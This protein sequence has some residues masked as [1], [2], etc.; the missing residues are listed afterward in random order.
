VQGCW[1]C[2]R[3]L[4]LLSW[5]VRE[6]SQDVRGCCCGQ[7]IHCY[8]LVWP[9]HASLHTGLPARALLH[10]GVASPC[11]V[12]HWFASYTLLWP[13]HVL[14]H[15]SVASPCIPAPLFRSDHSHGVC[16]C[17]FCCDHRLL[18]VRC[19]NQKLAVHI[20]V[21]CAPQALLLR[22]VRGSGEVHLDP[23]VGAR[24]LCVR[25]ARRNISSGCSGCCGCCGS[26][27]RRVC[28]AV[29]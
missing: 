14:L 26:C 15:T 8:T 11:I 23:R 17:T 24:R 21:E 6:L 27:G 18:A 13:A 16:A 20:T 1:R 7:L 10:A 28:L 22:C 29:P 12:T 5:Q 4:Q 2:S 19:S 25:A 9:T 3:V